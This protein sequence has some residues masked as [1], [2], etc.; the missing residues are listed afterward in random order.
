MPPRKPRDQKTNATNIILPSSDDDQGLDLSATLLYNLC[1]DSFKIVSSS[2]F[3]HTALKEHD[4]LV[5]SG[6][7]LRLWGGTVDGQRLEH[8]L[9]FSPE[10]NN[11]VLELL[12][13]IGDYLLQRRY[14]RGSSCMQW[15]I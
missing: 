10:L 5:D 12:V 1:L 14:K 3:R 13:S 15:L 6:V 9:T 7:Q 2:L 4:K 11:S 8:A